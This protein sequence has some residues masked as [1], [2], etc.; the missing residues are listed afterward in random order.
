MANLSYEDRKAIE[1]YLLENPINSSSEWG[2]ITGDIEN[3]TDLINYINEQ[4]PSSGGNSNVEF[5]TYSF[6]TGQ[7]N[8]P[9]FDDGIIQIGWDSP[10]N[11]VE[12]TML[13]E[14]DGTGDMVSYAKTGSSSVVSTYITQLNLTYDIFPAG[15]SALEVL[16]VLISA[17]QDPSFPTYR[18]TFH[19]AGSS[20]NTIVEVKKVI[21]KTI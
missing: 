21:P 17:E 10:A 7:D 11:D 19:N 6:N 5:Y 4:T 8:R 2:S 20:Y 14:P 3:Q 15:L 13:T 18:M 1:K 9:F 12:L 16:V